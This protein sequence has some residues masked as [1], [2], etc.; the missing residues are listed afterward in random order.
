MIVSETS[1]S[2]GAEIDPVMNSTPTELETEFV[3]IPRPM[4]RNP[5]PDGGALV[6][7]AVHRVALWRAGERPVMR[8]EVVEGDAG[9][10]V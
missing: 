8:Q 5:A 10:A 1:A 4:E 2:P 9:L 6:Y 3:C 7:R